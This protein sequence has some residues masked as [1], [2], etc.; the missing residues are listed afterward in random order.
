MVFRSACLSDARGGP[1]WPENMP[2]EVGVGPSS[3]ETG[4]KLIDPG[5]DV[6]E[7]GRKPSSLGRIQAQFG[8]ILA[9][10][11]RARISTTV[12]GKI[13]TPNQPGLARF[14]PNCGRSRLTPAGLVSQTQTRHSAAL[15]KRILC[16]FPNAPR[17]RRV[18]GC[19]C[20]RCPESRNAG[21]G[22]QTAS[23]PPVDF[24][25]SSVQTPQTFRARES[26]LARGHR[27][28]ERVACGPP[29]PALEDL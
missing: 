10:S 8:L 12:F 13:P 24:G 22:T 17:S 2:N 23:Q 5:S 26:R 29:P 15:V 25:P 6:A 1:N 14:R 11:D 18:K 19:F 3:I 7:I 16:C 27:L 4:P 28:L 9:V 21:R 20:R